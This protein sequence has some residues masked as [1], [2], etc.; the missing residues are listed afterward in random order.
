MDERQLYAVVHRPPNAPDALQAT[1]ADLWG[2]AF[3][4]YHHCARVAELE[5]RDREKLRDSLSAVLSVGNVITVARTASPTLRVEF[6][7]LLT[8]VLS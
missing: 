1:F 8:P 3:A 6:E 4:V 2:K 5:Q 7:V